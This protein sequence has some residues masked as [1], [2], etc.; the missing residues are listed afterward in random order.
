M[1]VNKIDNIGFGAKI[2][3]S[4]GMTKALE[5]A[6][7]DAINGGSEG[8]SRAAKFYNSLRTIEKDETAKKLVVRLDSP[9]LYPHIKV[10]GAIRF[11][12]QIGKTENS[13]AVS[14]Q[15]AINEFVENRY[16]LK[17]I[18]DEA[19]RVNLKKAFDKWM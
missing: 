3:S 4:E 7:N 11:L 19:K 16:F 13:I 6:K 10:D 8:I 17:G 12:E 5:L 14:I 15:N 9:R 18:K 1:Q 2:I